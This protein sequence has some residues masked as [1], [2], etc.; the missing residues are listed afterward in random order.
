MHLTIL[1]NLP[2][3]PDMIASVPEPIDY[4]AA[5]Y[6]SPAPDC[7]VKGTLFPSPSTGVPPPHLPPHVHCQGRLDAQ[8]STNLALPSADTDAL[9]PG[10][11][12]EKVVLPLPPD[13]IPEK[14]YTAPIQLYR[15]WIG[16]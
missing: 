3:L 1:P 5:K 14:G 15:S 9:A 16:T 13:K 11:S 12:V 2:P 4:P 8:I 10:E 7:P 6:P